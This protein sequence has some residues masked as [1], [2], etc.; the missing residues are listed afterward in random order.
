MCSSAHTSLQRIK[1]Y[2]IAGASVLRK[3]PL[4][5]LVP[6]PTRTT[7][8]RLRLPVRQDLAFGAELILELVPME[9]Q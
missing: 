9:E 6:A 1:V 3:R 5:K 8:Q 7:V 2:C 4:R